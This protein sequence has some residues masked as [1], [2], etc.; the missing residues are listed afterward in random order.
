M[1]SCRS[2]KIIID[3]YPEVKGSGKIMVFDENGP[4]EMMGSKKVVKMKCEKC[5]EISLDTMTTTYE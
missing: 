3:I 4:Q 1:C 5:G 2:W